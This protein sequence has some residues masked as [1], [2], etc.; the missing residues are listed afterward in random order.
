M[1]TQPDMTIHF[2]SF[3]ANWIEPGDLIAGVSRELHLDVLIALARDV[4]EHGKVHGLCRALGPGRR[5]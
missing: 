4:T 5:R 1:A 2:Q 3:R